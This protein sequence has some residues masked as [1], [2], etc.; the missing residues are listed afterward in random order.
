M[1][2]LRSDDWLIVA[3]YLALVLA[4]GWW[5]GREE[6]TTEDFVAGGRRVPWWAV[7]ASIVAT[8]ISAVTFLNVPG[9]AFTGDLTYLQF[10]LGSILGRL[11]VAYLF[12]AAFYR[13]RYL[14]VYSYLADRFGPATRYA[15]TSL[16]LLSRFLGSGLRLSLAALGVGVIFG[17][18]F[19]P[20]LFGFTVLALGYTIWGG[21]KAIIWTD[22][23]QAS[24][25]IGGG[26]AL[27]SWL[28][29][30]LGWGTI[31]AVADEAQK[32]KLFHWGT[33]EGASAFLLQP[34]L[35]YLAALNGFLATIAALGTDQDLTQRMLTCRE[36]AEARRSVILSG[37]VGVPVAGLFLCLG[38][39][40]F[41]LAQ[42]P[43]A[44]AWLAE[45]R[46]DGEVAANRV[47]PAFIAH[48]SPHL[49]RGFLIAGVFAAAMSSVDSAMGAL[50]STLTLDLYRPLLS[51]HAEEKHLVLVSRL[52]V[53]GCA[54]VLFLLAWAFS[55][56]LDH[57]WLALQIASIPA[58]TMLGIF[59]LGLT[60]AR[61]SDR[62]NLLAMALGLI[63]SS[64]LFA[65]LK[66]GVVAFAWTWLIVLGMVTTFAVGLCFTPA[67]RAPRP[68][69]V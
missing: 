22:L 65:L 61:G 14:T 7:L 29:F 2:G 54:V 52:N 21:I 43:E 15:A 59:L 50:S 13:G 64:T 26:V 28:Q 42:L 23:I 32:L 53:L 24:V 48:G 67:H 19:L 40:F 69:D 5:K 66:I 60:T 36:P 12:L 6:S 37:L 31:F 35:F 1:D 17:F 44:T 41:A 18:P 38:L 68:R 4:V 45:A 33:G 39:G 34:N 63:L 25:F 8:E 10:G 56:S 49:L 3:A 62:G 11:V 58:G 57:L 47:F 30:E 51:P 55:D 27:A 16:F 46:V 20:T 9:T